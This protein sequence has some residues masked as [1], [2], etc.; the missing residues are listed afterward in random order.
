MDRLDPAAIDLPGVDLRVVEQCPST[1]S[2]LLEETRRTSAP[3]L[4]ATE[5]QT[6]G[7]GRRGR[8]WHSS[9][10][11]DVT[12]S[13][14]RNVARP[15]R[16]LAALS[17]VA[18]VAIA[19]ALRAFGVTAS[20]KWPNDLVVGDAKLG[21]ILVGTRNHD[22][23][24]LA[25]IGIGINCRREPTLERRLRRRVAFLEDFLAPLPSRNRIIQQT[26]SALLEAL[27]AFE[28]RGFDALRADWLAM[29]AHA[30]H[31]LRV[32]LADGRMVTGIATGL[33]DD[34]GLRLRTRGGERAIRSGR[35]VSARTA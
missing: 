21:G 19:K 16:E 18:G 1:N 10:G 27:A 13:L 29:H 2:A 24:S 26:A 23:A 9:A 31:K 20:L 8:R 22:R 25:V 14:A 30:G 32:R 6:A 28:A 34:G 12:F 3:V 4:L 5:E 33:A 17:L 15:P 35:V 7:R 11:R